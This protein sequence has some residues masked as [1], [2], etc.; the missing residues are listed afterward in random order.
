MPRGS[1]SWA[2]TASCFHTADSGVL[3]SPLAGVGEQVRVK[4]QQR[5]PDW[6]VARVHAS[7]LPGRNLRLPAQPPPEFA[8]LPSSVFPLFGPLGFLASS[9]ALPDAAAAQPVYISG[10]NQD[11]EGT[12]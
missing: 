5:S 9:Q 7:S 10:G 11:G 6:A 1:A 3:S 2:C 8:A 12:S 4:S